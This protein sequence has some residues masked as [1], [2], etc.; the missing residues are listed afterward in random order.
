MRELLFMICSIFSI[1][2]LSSCEQKP[3]SE[4]IEVNQD[5]DEYYEF[6]DFILTN[7]D[8]QNVSIALPDE[9]AEIGASINPVITHD[10][11]HKWEIVVGPK[12]ELHILDQ[13]ELQNLIKEEKDRISR[14]IFNKITYIEEND[15]LLI[16]KKELIPT[17]MTNAS[18]DIGVEHKTLHIFGIR[19]VGDYNFVLHSGLEGVPDEYILELMKKSIRSFKKFK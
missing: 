17:G 19:K 14:E 9:T 3:V 11:A 10:E 13:G 7:Y 2:L 4:K 16:Y 8:L 6:Q 12:F 15:S 5:Y 18:S 1:V